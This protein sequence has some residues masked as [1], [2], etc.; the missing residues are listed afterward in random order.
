MSNETTKQP[1]IPALGFDWLTRFYDPVLRVTLREEKFKRLLIEQARLHPGQNVLDL[2]CGTATLTIMLKQ[3]CPEARVVGLDGD[4][5]VLAIARE[6]IA[7]AG[8]DVELHQG[9]AFA[10]PF[11]PAS[12]HRVVSSLVFHHLTTENKRRT[13][14][15]VREILRPGGEL[16]VADWGKPHNALMWIASLGIRWLDG[17][18]TT[19]DNLNGHLVGLMEQAGFS[20][21]EET[22]QEM[23]IF[24][25][26][27]LYR[28]VVPREAV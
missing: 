20:T 17:A 3:S 6:K 10:P 28:A 7:A 15:K 8:V 18:E 22:H 27:S 5:N 2:G 14:A 11:T 4:P 21:A 12:F 25:T 16:H 26:L 19:A 1:Y 24:G 9:M 23:T 13:L